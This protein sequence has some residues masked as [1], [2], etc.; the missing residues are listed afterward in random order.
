MFKF[1]CQE[2]QQ[3]TEEARSEYTKLQLE[4]KRLSAEC[5]AGWSACDEEGDIQNSVPA[6]REI[7][8]EILGSETGKQACIALKQALSV[9]QDL[10]KQSKVVLE[11]SVPLGVELL[12]AL[13]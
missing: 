6:L 9:L 10:V 8:A 2:I 1:F 13:L 11:L 4:E 12:S 5:E 3:K 7:P